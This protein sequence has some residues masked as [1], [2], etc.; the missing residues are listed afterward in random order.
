M[1]MTDPV[2]DM[3]TRIRNAVMRRHESVVMP[4]SRLKGEIARLLK[5]EGFIRQYYKLVT[6]GPRTSLKI[7]LKYLNED[8]PV[9][10][11]LTR[12]S[13]PGR[14]VYV[15]SDRVP[16]VKGGYGVAILSTSR[17]VLTDKQSRQT[18]VGGE[19]LCY[20]W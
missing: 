19:V 3:L 14:R 12:V 13:T 20:V 5:E 16:K 7:E 6:D 11:G 2:A 18:R 9:I 10:G 17:G 8:E 4:A 1:S 15:G